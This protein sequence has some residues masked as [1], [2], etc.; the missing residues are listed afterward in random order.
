M[1][2]IE[3]VHVTKQYPGTTR[4]AVDDVSLTVAEGTLC[5][6]L[7]TS[8]S[9][10]T[11][12]L[13][14]IN[15][16]IDPSAGQILIDGKPTTEQ[17]PIALRRSIGYVIQQI[18]LFPH[19][20]IAENV[21]VVPNILGQPKDATAARVDALLNLVGLDPAEY[22]NRFP[23][24]LSGGQQQRVG[25]ARA[26][27]ADPDLLLMDEPFGALDAITRERMQDE[28]RRI[29]RDVHKTIVFVTHDVQ[30]ALKL[31]DQIAVMS[32]GQLVQAGPPA[33]L[34]LHPAD[35]FVARLLGADNPLSLY[36]HVSVA[37]LLE[38][39]AGA[40]GGPIDAATPVLQALLTL[41]QTS[42][43]ALAVSRDGTVVGQVSLDGI[44]RRLRAA[45]GQK[46][47]P[48]PI[49]A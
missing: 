34:L 11:T 37:T 46:T 10:K 29:Q 49:N 48:L 17:D 14:M 2:K 45:P 30:E 3:F 27:A 38:P 43:A 39:L 22:R 35:D 9:G 19:L 24:Q 18:G 16:L 25:L 13:R 44:Q 8:G 5:M 20:T 36:E 33:E 6:L 12:L 31:G 1:A 47:P 7:G 42:A 28:L 4:A 26:L 23:R 40:T 15:R 21:R 32:D 41:V